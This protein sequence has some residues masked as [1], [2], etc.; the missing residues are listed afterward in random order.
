MFEVPMS[1]SAKVD[2]DVCQHC[3]FVWFDGREVDSLVP[4]PPQQSEP[5]L[6]QEAREAIALEGIKQIIGEAP[7]DEW[8]KQIAAF[9]GLR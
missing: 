7:P 2:V 6:P 3:H 1:D 4:L 9:F 5:K 8:W